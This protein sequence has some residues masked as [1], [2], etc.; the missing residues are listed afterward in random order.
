MWMARRSPTSTHSERARV[1]AVYSMWRSSRNQCWRLT[2]TITTGYSEPCAHRAAASNLYFVTRTG[3]TALN[4]SQPHITPAAAAAA[5]THLSLVDRD[6]PGRQ[7]LPHLGPPLVPHRAPPPPPQSTACIAHPAQSRR[8]NDACEGKGIS[9]GRDHGLI[10]HPPAPCSPSPPPPPPDDNGGQ[11]EAPRR[12][13]MEPPPSTTN[14]RRSAEAPHSPMCLGRHRR[15]IGKSQS[16]WTRDTQGG[17]EHGTPPPPWLNSTVATST[18]LSSGAGP[19]L[20]VSWAS[21]E[22]WVSV[23]R[24]A[25]AGS[26]ER[27]GAHPHHHSS[28]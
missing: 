5:A 6:G 1:T 3:A 27:G 15:G 2:G 23:E 10:S 26:G 25:S 17:R 24:A 21:V 13:D 9:A 7:Q 18:C 14:T 4:P 16:Q 11:A 8:H 12:T 20:S 28:I 19:A 22:R